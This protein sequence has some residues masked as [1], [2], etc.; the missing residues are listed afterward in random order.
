MYYPKK[1]IFISIMILVR[2]GNT[3]FRFLIR[4]KSMKVKMLIVL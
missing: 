1:L 4:K 3:S 2:S